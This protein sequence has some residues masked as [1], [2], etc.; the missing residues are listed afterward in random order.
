[1]S[2]KVEKDENDNYSIVENETE[3]IV[4]TSKSEKKARNV[5]RNLNLGAGF[6]GWTPDFFCSK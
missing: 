3:R 6:Q 5:C 2:Y 1:M 4:D